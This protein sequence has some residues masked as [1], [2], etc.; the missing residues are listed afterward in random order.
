MTTPSDLPQRLRDLT[1][2][3]GMIT[4]EHTDLAG[5][6]TGATFSDCMTYRYRLWRRWAANKAKINFLML[7]PSTADELKNDATVERCERRARSMGGGELIVTNLFGLRS[8]DPRALLTVDDPVGPDNDSAIIEVARMADMVVCAWGT[9]GRYRNRGLWVQAML[10]R[11]H[12]T[13]HH[14]GLT[15]HLGKSQSP[16]PKHPLYVPYS[17]KPER[18]I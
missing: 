6:V 17:Q 10:N 1:R 9:H 12:I 13:L 11:F 7:N 14:L 2:N 5:C 8:T 16:Q 15:R 4:R 3:I 18:F